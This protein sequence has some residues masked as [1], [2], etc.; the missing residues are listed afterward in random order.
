MVVIATSAIA[1]AQDVV[2]TIPPDDAA[3]TSAT[4]SPTSATT[5]P[6]S[7]APTSATTPAP[8]LSTPSLTLTR[9]NHS[10][11]LRGWARASAIVGLYRTGPQ[12][13]PERT[14]VPHD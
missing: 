14:D 5:S 6:T 4:T 7:A 9:A 13:P 8:K 11:D 1:S 10:V 2:E 12:S 3:P